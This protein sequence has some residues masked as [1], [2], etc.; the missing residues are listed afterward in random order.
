ML[1]AAKGSD[2]NNIDD[3]RI[4][5]RVRNKEDPE[6]NKRVQQCALITRAVTGNNVS[7]QEFYDWVKQYLLSGQKSEQFRNG[8]SITISGT[9]GE[10]ITDSREY[11]GEMVLLVLK[12]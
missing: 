1:A 10:K 7:M 8:W 2:G 5:I 3:I 12:K 6:H 4:A 9:Q 11:L